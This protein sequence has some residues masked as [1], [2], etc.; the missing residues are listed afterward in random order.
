M[1]LTS[2]LNRQ[3]A[4]PRDLSARLLSRLFPDSAP[5]P[6][7][8]APSG[9][10]AAQGAA[11]P[12][13][14]PVYQPPPPAPVAGRMAAPTAAPTAAAPPPVAASP[15]PAPMG[16]QGTG[17]PLGM[18]GGWSQKHAAPDPFG[19]LDPDHRKQLDDYFNSLAGIDYKGSHES[20]LMQRAALAQLMRGWEGEG[21]IDYTSASPL[22]DQFSNSRN[23]LEASLAARG[24]SGGVVGGAMSNSYSQEARGIGD[25]IR[26]LI[27]QRQSQHHSDYQRFL[28]WTRQLNAQGLGQNIAEQN[29]PGFFGDLAGI[30]GG[31]GGK[32]LGGIIP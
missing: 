23:Q 29:D 2:I 15:P 16:P 30:V 24:L 9:A 13:G 22:A 10:M 19:D 7:P 31:I 4:Q 32:V 5:A 8:T 25:Y 11:S 18:I 14:L 21:E 17:G 1:A 6:Q 12:T 28:D 27:Q 3:T 26:Q 20:A